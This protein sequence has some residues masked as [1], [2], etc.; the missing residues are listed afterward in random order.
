MTEALLEHI[1][2]SADIVRRGALGAML[3]SAGCVSAD[4]LASALAEQRVTGERIGT[5]LVRAGVDPEDV[6]R[7][8]ALQ[9]RMRYLSPPVRADPPAAGLVTASLARR[10]QALPIRCDERTVTVAI[11]DP[12]DVAA[13]DDLRFRLGR[14]IEPVVVSAATLEHAIQHAYDDGAVRDLARRFNGGARVRGV[15]QAPSA[16]ELTALRRASEAAPVV[17]LVNLLVERAIAR[18]ASD[19]HVEP[20]DDG[21]HVRAR[22]DG[23]LTPLFEIPSEAAGAVISRIKIMAGLDIAVRLRP[24]DGRASAA[25]T[26]GTVALRV[27]TLP[28]LGGEKVVIRLLRG[29]AAAPSLDDLGMDADTRVRVDRMLAQ[30][31]GVLLV[32]GP[33]GSGKTTTLYGMLASLDRRRRNIITLEDPVEYRLP[34]ITQVQVHTRAGLGFADALR[35]VLRQDPDIIMVGELRDRESAGIALSAA[36]TGH[37]VLATLH[38]NDAPTAATRLCELGMPPY[39]VAGTL[40]GVVAQRLARRVCRQCAGSGCQN[41]DAGLHGRTGVYEVLV[42]DDAIRARILRRA[43]AHVIRAAARAGGMRTLGE[44]ARR[45]VDAGIT[46]EDEVAGLLTLP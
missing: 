35:A 43:P 46:R 45:L 8:L 36:L 11:S 1:T 40:L 33:T 13:L 10:L 21:L 6:A 27:S 24:Q 9:V 34:G 14:R 20:V 37:L 41:C 29:G 17:E 18:R 22:I 44:D 3:Q 12:L 4:L 39:L 42:T 30:P 28:A 16:E 32:T 26:N 23:V 2:Q 5:V 15:A 25:G 31:H 19:V 7:M 38:T